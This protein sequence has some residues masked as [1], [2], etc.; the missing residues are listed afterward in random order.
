MRRS[1]ALFAVALVFS[2]PF[3]VAEAAGHVHGSLDSSFNGTGKVTT[4]IGSGD[5]AGYA[6]AIQKNGKLVAA[7]T[8]YNGSGNDFAL[9]RYNTNGSL[10]T[11]F[12][13]TGKVTTSI[14][15]GYDVAHALAIQKDG[16]LVAAGYSWNGT[17]LD[18]ALV[19]YNTNGSL[20]TSFNGTGKVTTLIGPGNDVAHA[21]AIQKDG[22]LVAAGTAWS[23]TDNDFALVRYNTNGSLDSSFGFNGAGEVTTPIGSDDD[24]AAALAIQKDGKL[25]AAG[26]SWNGT[27]F[28][29]ALVR[30]NTNGSLD[31]SF[32]GFGK[33]TT[34]I[35]LSTDAA[36]ALMIQKD[37]KLV[38]A[39][40]SIIGSDGE[41]ALVRYWP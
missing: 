20:D 27:D 15:S 33:L 29:F 26:D 12:N 3:G 28:D 7:G 41:F 22:K 21:L 30:Y 2:L 36:D 11:S 8:S 1:S 17:D 6:L 38:A 39:G 13:G 25:V 5:D 24:E 19:R 35:G 4:L 23:G 10:D 14:G 16:K 9:V 31:S 18:F 32:N 34:S 40:G 37:G